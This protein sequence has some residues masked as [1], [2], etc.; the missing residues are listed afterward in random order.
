M[1]GS[2]SEADLLA[3]LYFH[4]MRIRPEEPDWPDRDRFVLSKGHASIG[5][6]ATLALRSYF[7]LEDLP[8]FD[9]AGRSSRATRT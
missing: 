9:G 4:V 6:Y 1:G 7:P 5:L 8:T 3:A 2:L